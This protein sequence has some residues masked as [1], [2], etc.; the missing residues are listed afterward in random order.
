MTYLSSTRFVRSSFGFVLPVLSILMGCGVDHDSKQES[1]DIVRTPK[2]S[3]SDILSLEDPDCDPQRL[4]GKMGPETLIWMADSTGQIR[5]QK[6]DMRE[7]STV[8]L[9]NQYIRGTYWHDDFETLDSGQKAESIESILADYLPKKSLNSFRSSTDQS[10][11]MIG[12]CKPNGGYKRNS[13][14]NVALA[15]AVGVRQTYQFSYQQLRSQ[16]IMLPRINLIAQLKL[17]LPKS[18]WENPEVPEYFSDNASWFMSNSSPQEYFISSFPQSRVFFDRY[19]YSYWEIPSIF[20]HEYGHHI[21]R[22]IMRFQTQDTIEGRMLGAINEGFSDLSSWLSLR[23]SSTMYQQLIIDDPS[24]KTRNPDSAAIELLLPDPST[25]TLI[26]RNFPK[27]VDENFV[28]Y[29]TSDSSASDTVISVEE[30]IRQDLHL[31]GAALAHIFWK[32]SETSNP[33]VD[34]MKIQ[35]LNIK[36][37]NKINRIREQTTGLQPTSLSLFKLYI[38]E[39]IRVIWDS[40][41]FDQQDVTGRKLHSLMQKLIPGLSKSLDLPDSLQAFGPR[42]HDVASEELLRLITN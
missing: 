20:G 11:K 26:Q 35:E 27:K 12:F 37:V 19:Q 30:L 24:N 8:G 39:M 10:L 32:F 33:T 7:F 14:E 42:S 22:Q 6:F 3:D 16:G 28:N 29:F 4:T 17:M 41:P 38:Q 18:E 5:Q 36:W 23:N 40:V 9:R 2:F 34:F 25:L 1:S 21:F 13:L 31:S 15:M